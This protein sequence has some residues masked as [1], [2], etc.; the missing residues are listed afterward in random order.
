VRKL[1]G[2]T[3]VPPPPPPPTSAFITVALGF[4]TGGIHNRVLRITGNGFSAGEQVKLEITTRV[5]GAETGT[6]KATTTVNSLSFIE[7]VEQNVVSSNRTWSA[8]Q[9]NRRVFRCEPPDLAALSRRVTALVAEALPRSL[10][11]KLHKIVGAV[12]CRGPRLRGSGCFFA[13][14]SLEDLYSPSCLVGKF[15]EVYSQHPA[16]P[17]SSEARDWLL[18]ASM[19][20]TGA[21]GDLAHSNLRP[22][23][24]VQSPTRWR[25][26][27]CSTAETTSLLGGL[28][29]TRVNM[30]PPGS[31]NRSY[32]YS[33]SPGKVL[34]PVQS[35]LTS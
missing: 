19:L 26:T 11:G 5:D 15:S 22:G 14:P 10:K 2:G 32:S 35:A 18:T 8:Q 30:S 25:V 3:P 24:A 1:E 16:Q 29:W 23:L 33:T 7:P 27:R 31:M 34:R 9:V 4:D 28:V 6:A 13:I 17:G 20:W 12:L 21:V